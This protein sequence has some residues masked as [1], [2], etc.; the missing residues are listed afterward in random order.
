MT[1]TKMTSYNNAIVNAYTYINIFLSLQYM[2]HNKD[3]IYDYVSSY[4]F[5]FIVK[6]NGE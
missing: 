4:V 3:I 1:M 6:D 2:C 5:A